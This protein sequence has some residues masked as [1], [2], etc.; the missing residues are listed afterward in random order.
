LCRKATVMSHLT[1][2][3]S[4]VSCF[5]SAPSFIFTF[6][7][8]SVRRRMPGNARDSVQISSERASQMCPLYTHR[9]ARKRNIRNMLRVRINSVSKPK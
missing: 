8:S 7:R 5:L 4:F 2:T 1:R 3:I 9:V 6:F